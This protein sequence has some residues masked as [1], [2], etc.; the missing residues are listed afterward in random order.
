[1]DK[2]KN[3]FS[4]KNQPCY[5]KDGEFIGWFS[6]SMAAAIFVFCKDADGIIHVLA[7]ERGPGAA[8]FIGYWN[9]CCGYLDFNETL[10][11]CACRELKEETG[12]I[13]KPYELSFIGYED[14]PSENHQNVT[15]R[16]VYKIMNRTIDEI[17]FSKDD[18]EK[19]EVGEIKWIP[20]FDVHKYKWAFK[21]DE[22]IYKAFKSVY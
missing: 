11:E 5:T 8:D 22:I 13:A 3:I 1:M 10:V 2:E 18:N 15:F 7:S 17:S 21:H 14:N 20:I 12:V 6:R 4:T 19:D 9:C 16:F